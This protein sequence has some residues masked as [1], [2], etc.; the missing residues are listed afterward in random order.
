[1]NQVVYASR[2]GNT[3]KLAEAIAKGA[4]ARAQAVADAGTGTQAD[5]LF[6]GG[7]IY[8]GKIDGGLRTYLQGLDAAKVGRVVVFGTAA[9]K[10][11][12]LEE[13]RGILSPKG[14]AVSDEAFQCPGSFLLAH[15][16]R[17]NDDDLRE[18]EAFAKR[19]SA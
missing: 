9:G 7:S 5:V 11:S 13:V 16:G 10:K 1:M 6:V 15:R 14:I 2:G 12:A 18:A 4:G 17:P 19:M 3:K 8:A